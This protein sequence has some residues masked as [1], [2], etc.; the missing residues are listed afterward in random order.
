MRSPNAQRITR[1]YSATVPREPDS[2]ENEK[3]DV[4]P[5]DDQDTGN[6]PSP[7]WSQSS[8]SG[9]WFVLWHRLLCR[10][11]LPHAPLDPTNATLPDLQPE[12][13]QSLDATHTSKNGPLNV[14]S[15]DRTRKQRS[16]AARLPE[17]SGYLEFEPNNNAAPVEAEAQLG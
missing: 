17:D 7:T 1:T 11:A 15:S 14:L 8:E 2:F 3:M 5:G 9:C 12:Y 4:L 6:R 16:N 10:G 13:N